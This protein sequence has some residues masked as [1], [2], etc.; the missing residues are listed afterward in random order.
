MRPIWFR[1]KSVDNNK[2]VYGHLYINRTAGEYEISNYNQ[3]FNIERF[4]TVV[5]PETIG[6][7]IGVSDKYD[8]KIFEG[9]II[10]FEWNGC[11]YTD[12]V[13]YDPP[14]FTLKYHE[15]TYLSE[16]EVISNIYDNPELEE[17]FH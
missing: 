10:Q 16:D 14:T 1:G 7:Y 13:V 5:R 12:V 6:Q 4:T 17:L 8:K 15:R 9:D 11:I 2:W 3:D